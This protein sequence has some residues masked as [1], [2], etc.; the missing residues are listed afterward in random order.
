MKQKSFV[1][2]EGLFGDSNPEPRLSQAVVDEF[3]RLLDRPELVE[4]DLQRFLS[5]HCEIIATAFMHIIG[6]VVPK[7]AFGDDHISDFV[8]ADWRQLWAVT[9]VELEPSDAKAFNKNGTPARRL[10]S[11]VKQISDWQHWIERHPSYF[12][13]KIARYHKGF[14]A[15]LKRMKFTGEEAEWIMPYLQRW[16]YMRMQH[17]VIIGR[18]GSDFSKDQE[19]RQAFSRVSPD[20]LSIYSYDWLLDVAR[21]HAPNKAIDSDEE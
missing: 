18:R 2:R 9:L 10:A 7:F 3:A 20:R 11:A 8:V 6:F 16:R 12:D 15:D 21:H 5:D 1:C 13:E 19:D 14:L 4:E 17:V